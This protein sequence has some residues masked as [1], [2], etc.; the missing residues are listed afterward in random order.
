MITLIIGTPAQHV[1]R[2]E[3]CLPFIQV[4][5]L[6]LKYITALTGTRSCC[7]RDVSHTTPR[8]NLKLEEPEVAGTALLEA[9]TLIACGALFDIASTALKIWVEW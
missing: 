1:C 6:S 9:A 3:G 8:M 5:N 2:D 7:M 4:T